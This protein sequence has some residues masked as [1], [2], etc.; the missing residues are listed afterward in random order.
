MLYV[1]TG[2]NRFKPVQTG[3]NRFKPVQ[4]GSNREKTRKNCTVSSSDRLYKPSRYFNCHH[5]L[6]SISTEH[7]NSTLQSTS[8]FRDGSKC[9]LYITFVC[10]KLIHMY[11]NRSPIFAHLFRRI[12]SNDEIH[13]FKMK[14][15]VWKKIQYAKAYKNGV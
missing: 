3:S 10:R 2:S 12:T 13:M 11:R 14:Q 4:S 8:R 5:N 6:S 7:F 15:S 1:R 9:L